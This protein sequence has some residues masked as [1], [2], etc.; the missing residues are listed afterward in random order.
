[1]LQ[2]NGCR[3]TGKQRQ[4]QLAVI[5]LTSCSCACACAFVRVYVCVCC[6][7]VNANRRQGTAIWPQQL[8]VQRH[9]AK[10]GCVCADTVDAGSCMHRGWWRQHNRWQGG[11]GMYGAYV[12]NSDCTTAA[13]GGGHSAIRTHRIAQVCGGL[14]WRRL[15][16]QGPQPPASDG[17]P[18]PHTHETIAAGD[19]CVRDVNWRAGRWPRRRA[20][21][22][23]GWHGP[24]DVIKRSRCMP[25]S[26]Y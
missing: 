19:E 3:G 5:S 8:Q 6:A 10:T 13:G 24:H 9:T 23:C 20:A 16:L 4:V 25:G 17:G 2:I 26:R 12:C 22:G 14:R 1:M 7:C 11:R 18:R 15:S 21:R